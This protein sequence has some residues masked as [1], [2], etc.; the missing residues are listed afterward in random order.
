MAYNISLTDEAVAMLRAIRDRRIQRKIGDRI[1]GLAQEPEIQGKPLIG[2]L[3]RYR[4]IHAAGRYRIIYQVS[5]DSGEVLVFALGIRK[6]K[7][8]KDI[9]ELARKLI[10]LRLVD[11]PP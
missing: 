1:N 5:Q 6:E 9:Y 7:S 3:A 11:R 2:E 8:R 10:Q 4:S